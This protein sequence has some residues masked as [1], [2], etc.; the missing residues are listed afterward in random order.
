MANTEKGHKKVAK[1]K[2]GYYKGKRAKKPLVTTE[3]I[4]NMEERMQ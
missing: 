4:K 1:S 2:I 3:M